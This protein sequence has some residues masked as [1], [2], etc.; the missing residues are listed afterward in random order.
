MLAL[1]VLAALA[2]F[3]LLATVVW[4][5]LSGS[6]AGPA[7]SLTTTYYVEA[8]EDPFTY[9]IFINTVLYSA[10]ALAVA[11]ALGMPIAW[12]VERTDFPGKALVFTLMSVSLVIPGFS[13]ALGWLFL[14]HPRI[15]LINQ[16][17]VAALGLAEAP[18]NIAS[19][20][21][22][23]AIEGLSLASVGFIMTSAAL[24]SINPSL[25]EAAM[26]A[27]ATN[28]RVLRRI[29]IPVLWPAFMGACIYIFTIGFSSFDVPAIL[30][31]PNRIFTF[32][33][34]IFNE[35]NPSVGTPRYGRVAV[36]GVAMILVATLLT[37]TYNRTQ[38]ES[39]RY[40]IVTGKAYRP[41]LIELKNGKIPA[42]VFVTMYFIIAQGLPVLV[43]IWVSGLPYPQ[44]PSVA[45]LDQFSFTNFTNLS[46]SLIGRALKNTFLLMLL[47]PTLTVF[48]SL[49][50]SWIVLRSKIPGRFLFDFFAFL[51]QA[52]PAI[53]FSVAAL[54]FAL[55]ITRIVPVYGTVAL[56][57]A[58]YT[59]ARLG[60][61]TR[62]TNSA[63]IQIHHEL[64]EAA[65]TSGA[66]L[67]RVLI[68][69]L[70]PLIAP[71][72]LY[73]WVWIALLAYRELT[74]P[75]L[76]STTSNQP[77]SVVVWGYV[78]SSA[79]GQAS[80]LILLM[81]ACLLPVLFL[82]WMAARRVGLAAV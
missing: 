15:G 14:L 17:L 52:V 56:L 63:L 34:Y 23:A 41:R 51:P 77:V 28:W 20:G 48:F 64:D 21:G 71:T 53:V 36:L 58:V 29:T 18:F 27:G 67:L 24:K 59:I 25:E 49:V 44:V 66:S 35:L 72:L 62:M 38:R 80:A 70:V 68:C 22:M 57:I 55:T 33:T 12:L 3:G 26:M 37:W 1:A 60:Y 11:L 74:L 65:L 19:I 16:G 40:A 69:I 54:L 43:L 39:G 81:L 13:V 32:P 6:A 75:V 5:S 30:G 8:L 42:I 47:V 73:S 2:V 4:L 76:I 82:Y 78:V 9:R 79:Y 45:A 46:A 50:I 10:L 61:G 31:L 7:R